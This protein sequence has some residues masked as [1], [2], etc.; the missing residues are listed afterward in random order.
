METKAG[1]RVTKP[2][3]DTHFVDSDSQCPY[4]SRGEVLLELIGGTALGNLR[5]CSDGEVAIPREFEK[6][7]NC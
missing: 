4:A 7:V 2:V 6:N 3:P 5:L 1:G